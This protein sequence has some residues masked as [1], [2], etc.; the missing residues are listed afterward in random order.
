M[1]INGILTKARAQSESQVGSCG[2]VKPVSTCKGGGPTV[3]GSRE[4][5]NSCLVELHRCGGTH[6][7]PTGSIIKPLA[8]VLECDQYSHRGRQETQL[9]FRAL[10][11]RCW[12]Q[13]W[14]VASPRPS[15]TCLSPQ[16]MRSLLNSSLATS[17]YLRGSSVLLL[18]N[19]TELLKKENST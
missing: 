6:Q 4:V 5:G 2:E 15:A 1:E 12:A 7:V 18:W 17:P 14:R 16:L 3:S 13:H 10:V 19:W 11:R 8:D 9:T